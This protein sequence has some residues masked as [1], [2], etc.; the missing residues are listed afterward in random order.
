LAGLAGVLIL[1]TGLDIWFAAFNGRVVRSIVTRDWRLFVRNAVVVFA[2]MMWPMSFVNNSIKLIISRLSLSFRARLT[3]HAHRQYLKD[4]TFYKVVNLDN[5]L[6][7]IDQ[8]LSQD[9]VKFADSLAHLYSDITKPLVDIGL[10]AWKLGQG[11]GIEA[12]FLML[13]YFATS[14]WILKSISPPFGRYTAKE[15]GL[16]GEFRYA[17]SRVIAHSEE[18][19]FYRGAGRERALLDGIFDR[20][21]GHAQRVQ[22]LKFGNG[23]VDS[24]LVKYC[25]TQLAYFLL[26]RPVFAGGAASSSSPAATSP[27]DFLQSTKIMEAYSRNSGYLINLSQAVG[28]LV[29]AGRDLTRFAGFTWRV[30]E[31]FAVLEDVGQRHRFQ[32]TVMGDAK[33]VSEV[34]IIDET[35]LS[36]HIEEGEDGGKFRG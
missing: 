22:V 6:Q 1:R 14:G 5:R 23:I 13:G 17:H 36:G 15:Q 31:M 7:N 11:L 35:E 34:R 9:I 18:I 10:F 4:L 32:R 27:A 2:V 20:I 29:L 30:A 8:V 26:S 19:A 16:E 21:V 25:A 28:R 12:P 3:Q 33:G 24:V